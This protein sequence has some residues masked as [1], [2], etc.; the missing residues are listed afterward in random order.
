MFGDEGMFYDLTGQPVHEW[1]RRIDFTDGADLIDV[2]DYVTGQLMPGTSNLPGGRRYKFQLKDEEN[3]PD[4]VLVTYAATFDEGTDY[5]HTYFFRPRFSLTVSAAT[6]VLQHGQSSEL[7]V[8]ATHRCFE[9]PPLWS[10]STYKMTIVN[11]SQY[12]SLVNTATGARGT[13]LSGIPHSK[14]FSRSVQFVADGD[15]PPQDVDVTIRTECTYPHVQPRELNIRVSKPN[16][17]S[18]SLPR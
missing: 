4:T 3:I 5:V 10:G 2:F 6:P 11:G 17:R 13:T 14:G 18:R 8:R 16:D 15:K 1:A 9:D 12:G 7:R